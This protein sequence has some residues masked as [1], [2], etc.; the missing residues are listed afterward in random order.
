M[1]A[2]ADR[3]RARTEE[4]AAVEQGALDA[5]AR[6][7]HTEQ[8]PA[9]LAALLDQA[10]AVLPGAHQVHVT[11]ADVES[12]TALLEAR[13]RRARVVDDLPE[14]GGVMVRDGAGRL[15]DNT[16]HTRLEAAW[17]ALRTPVAEGWTT[18][19]NS[20]GAPSTPAGPARSD[21]GP[22]GP[23]APGSRT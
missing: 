18:A 7:R 15:V 19:A 8:W 11:A 21:G 23:L 2:Q 1:A 3:R 4:L 22:A 6:L 16:L 5:L 13:G 14:P 10:W 20:I 12:A 17:A 9:V